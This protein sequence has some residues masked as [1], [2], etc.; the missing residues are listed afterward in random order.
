MNKLRKQISIITLLL[1][2]TKYNFQLSK[3][4]IKNTLSNFKIGKIS[5]K[6]PYSNTNY[7]EIIILADNLSSYRLEY[8]SFPNFWVSEI[9]QNFMIF[10]EK[11]VYSECIHG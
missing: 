5:S 11:H 9:I 8:V 3:I 2:K 4:V 1:D 6:Y 7:F 10:R